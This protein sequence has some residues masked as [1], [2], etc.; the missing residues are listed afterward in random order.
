[1]DVWPHGAFTQYY[2]LGF[3]K[4]KDKTWQVRFFVV[5]SE[6]TVLSLEKRKIK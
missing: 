1:M 3:E 6:R 2:C 4:E 5:I